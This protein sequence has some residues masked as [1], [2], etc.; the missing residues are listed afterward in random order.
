VVASKRYAN[1]VMLGD[2]AQLAASDITKALQPDAGRDAVQRSWYDSVGREVWTA[3]A[4]GTT[5][6]R[7]FDGAGDLVNTHEYAMRLAV[8]ADVST[9]VASGAD[10]NTGFTYDKAHRLLTSTDTAGVVTRTTYDNNGNVTRRVVTPPA[11]AL[12][13]LSPRAEIMTYDA[14]NRLVMHVGA[15]G[16]VTETVYDGLGRASSTIAYAKGIA[17]AE[18]ATLPSA[19]AIAPV[20]S[21]IRARVNATDPANRVTTINIQIGFGNHVTT[22]TDAEKNVSVTRL[23]GLDRT[24]HSEVRAAGSSTVINPIDTSYDFVG[25]VVATTDAN[26]TTE[27]HVYDPVGN[28]VSFT[29]RNG[30]TWTYTYDGAGHQLSETSP[31][32]HCVSLPA[33]DGAINAGMVAYADGTIITKMAYDALGRLISRTE[34]AGRTEE[35]TTSYGYDADGHQVLVTYPAFGVYTPESATALAANGETGTATRSETT[36]TPVARTVYDTLGNA[37][38]NLD[39]AGA[40][41]YKS[42]DNMGQVRY[43][44]DALGYVTGYERD[45]WGNVVRLTRYAQAIALPSGDPASGA[46]LSTSDIGAALSAT[47]VDHSAD[48]VVTTDYDAA[49]RA[50]AVRTPSVYTV[51]TSTAGSASTGY[52]Q[53]I[54]QTEY[55][56]FGDVTLVVDGYGR[57]DSRS[58]FTEDFYDRL[59]RKTSSI[60]AGG[61][62]TQWQYDALGHERERIERAQVLAGWVVGDKNN[63]TL[64]P[65]FGKVAG[66]DRWTSTDYDNLGRKKTETRHGTSVWDAASNATVMKDVSTTYQYDAVG[67]LLVTTEGVTATDEGVRTE[68]RFDALGRVWTV[69]AAPVPSSANGSSSTPYT[70]FDRDA[71]G[72]VV[73]KYEGFRVPTAPGE[74]LFK[75]LSSIVNPGYIMKGGDHLFSSDGRFDLH[76]DA[77]GV[78][79]ETDRV[80]N[81][82]MWQ[83]GPP[84]SGA[85]QFSFAANGDLVLSGPGGVVWS[86]GTAGKGG[87]SLALQID[88]NLVIYDS[89]KSPWQAIWCT[90]W[91]AP[92]PLETPSNFY[93]RYTLTQYDRAGHVLRVQDAAGNDKFS[94]VDVFGHVVKTWQTFTDDAGAKH[95]QYEVTQYDA[96]GRK[97]AVLTPAS[98]S[99]QVGLGGV[100][101]VSST[102]AT[103]Y[104]VLTSNKTILLS[105]QNT[106]NLNVAQ[107]VR[108]DLGS[109][110]VTVNYSTLD[111]NALIPASTTPFVSQPN[112]IGTSS[113][114]QKQSVT[115]SA[116]QAMSGVAF[117]W[118]DNLVAVGGIGGLSH[119]LVEQQDAAGNWITRYDG[120]ASAGALG[121]G[122]LL[123]DE[124]GSVAHVWSYNAFGEATQENQ[125]GLVSTTAYD[126]AGNAWAKW[127]AQGVMHGA[128]YDVL[129]RQTVQIERSSAA[130]VALSQA[131]V[132][133]AAVLDGLNDTVKTINTYDALGHVVRQAMP[134]QTV[135]DTMA[136][137]AVQL[138]A[139]IQS[140]SGT[141]PVAMG[142]PVQQASTT[143][144][145]NCTGLDKLGAGDVKVDFTLVTGSSSTLVSQVK[146]AAELQNGYTYSTTAY[147]SQTATL[148]QVTL[149]KRDQLGKWVPIAQTSGPGTT[150]T[151]YV[152][153]DVSAESILGADYALAPTT[154]VDVQWKPAGAPDSGYLPL[155][156]VGLFDN[157]KRFSPAAVTAN[158]LDLRVIV[159]RPGQTPLVTYTS[160]V[161]LV[162]PPLTATAVNVS[163]GQVAGS[164]NTLAWAPIANQQATLRV[165]PSGT[166]AWTA[167][168]LTVP[169]TGL[170]G[171]DLSSLAA[172]NYD[173]EVLFTPT[174]SAA[175]TSHATGSFA[176]TAA[177]PSVWVPPVNLPN[178]SVSVSGSSLQWASVAS[179]PNG[180]LQVRLAG[181]ATWQTLPVASSAG[182]QSADTLSLA[183]GTYDYALQLKDAAGN[184]L[185]QATGS[186][187][188]AATPPATVSTVQVPVSQ[189]TTITPADPA[190]YV[191][192]TAF[193]G[194][195]GTLQYGAP[196]VASTDANGQPIL[197]AGY[198]WAT[199]G[200]DSIGQPIVGVVA[201][202][203]TVVVREAFSSATP[204]TKE[205]VKQVAAAPTYSAAQRRAAILL[206]EPLDPYL[207][208][209]AGNILY[210]FTYQI[211]PVDPKPYVVG[212]SGG[213]NYTSPVFVGADANG[214]PILGQGYVW[215]N[216]IV[217]GTVLAQPYVVVTQVLQSQTIVTPGVRPAPTLAGSTTPPYAP[218]YNTAAIA[219]T[220]KATANANPGTVA[221]S[222]SITTVGT[223]ATLAAANLPGQN[224]P[225]IVA[226]YDRWGNELTQ[227]DVRSTAWVTKFEYDRDNHLVRQTS[228]DANGQLSAASAVTVQGYDALGRLAASMDARSNT[229]KWTYDGQGHVLA[230][231]HS[232][233][234]V[235]RYGYNAFGDRTSIAD[236]M[237]HVTSL[238]VD[239]LGRTVQ[240]TQAGEHV[241]GINA[242]GLPQDMGVQG[243]SQSTR[244]DELGRVVRSEGYDGEVTYNCWDAAGNQVATTL[245]AAPDPTA[246]PAA[247]SARTHRMSL[248][249]FDNQH[250]Q[251]ASRDANG[252]WMR[253]G[254]VNGRLDSHTDLGGNV[255][256]YSY[257]QAG[258]VSTA[259]TVAAVGQ[260]TIA[261]TDASVSTLTYSYD[262][263]GQTVGIVNDMTMTGGSHRVQTSQYAY[264]LAGHRVLERVRLNGELL[265]DNHLA[266]DTLGRLAVAADTRVSVFTEYDA[267]GNRSHVRT[268]VFKGTAADQAERYFVYDSMNRQVVV[269]ATSASDW[270]S[271]SGATPYGINIALVGNDQ[272][273]EQAYL[274][275]NGHR[276]TYDLHGNRTSDLA[277]GKLLHQQT[278]W[279]VVTPTVTD[280]YAR[281]QYRYDAL[282]RLSSA[283]LEAQQDNWVF[284]V[285]GGTVTGGSYVYTGVNN[286]LLLDLRR[287]DAGGHAEQSGAAT[288]G[289]LATL[290]AT[291]YGLS[292]T[293]TNPSLDVLKLRYGTNST[294]TVVSGLGTSRSLTHYDGFGQMLDQHSYSAAG[295]IQEQTSLV[296][297]AAG[298]VL[299]NHTVQYDDKGAQSLDQTVTSTLAWQDRAIEAGQSINGNWVQT[300]KTTN[301]SVTQR[302]DAAGNLLSVRDTTQAGNNRD[303]VNDSA[304]QALRVVQGD[305]V[306]G[307]SNPSLL[308]TQFQFIVNG[309]V[310]GRTGEAL[311][312]KQPK[313]ANGVPQFA[314]VQDLSFGFRAIDA[315]TVSGASS[316]T[317]Q[318]G[319]TLQGIAQQ[320]YGDAGLWYL[321]AEANGL[322][323]NSDLKVGQTLALPSNVGTA[324]NA[325]G[326]VRPYD[327]SRVIGDTSPNLP[328]PQGGGGCGG[329]GMLIV[330]V[331]AVV[332]A[333]VTQQ[334]VLAEKMVESA[335]AAG[336]IGAA[337]GSVA[338]QLVGMAIG[339]QD[340]FSWK[341]VGLAAVGGAVSGALSDAAKTATALQNVALKAAL[342]NAITQGIGVATGLQKKFD[343]RGVAASAAGAFAGDQM[344]GL[345]NNE[346]LQRVFGD[347]SNLAA[348]TI[349]GFV[350][351]TTTALARGGRVAVQQ[352]ATDAFGNALGE[353][354]AGAMLPQQA[355]P[356]RLLPSNPLNLDNM[357][358]SDLSESPSPSPS[359]T[360]NFAADVAARQRA[361]PYASTDGAFY[362]ATFGATF[363][364]AQ[365]Q[366]GAGGEATR[367]ITG[368]DGINNLGDGFARQFGRAATPEEAVKLANY[369]GLSSAHDVSNNREL[370]VPKSLSDLNAVGASGLQ[371]GEYQTRAALIEL[372]R[373][374][375]RAADAVA[376]QVVGNYVDASMQMDIGGSY[377]SEAST[378]PYTGPSW[379]GV[380]DETGVF[381]MEGSG[382]IYDTVSAN[383]ARPIVATHESMQEFKGSVLKQLEYEGKIRLEQ[384]AES[385]M[386]WSAAKYVAID[387]M[388]PGSP[389]EVATGVGG[390]YLAG[391]VLGLAG[392]SL[393]RVAGEGSFW[394][395]D[396]GEFAG[397]QMENAL[398]KTANVFR[399]SRFA[400]DMSFEQTEALKNLTLTA[401]E[402]LKLAGNT[403]NSL[404]PAFTVAQDMVTG[405]VRFGLN[406]R[407]GRVPENIVDALDNRIVN[408]PP[409]IRDGYVRSA[410][411]GTHAEIYAVNDLMLARQGATLSEIAV[412]TIETGNPAWARGMYKPA[413]PHCEYILNGVHYVK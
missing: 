30:A 228:V 279:G 234:G 115:V 249:V 256:R 162:A 389:G 188:V 393:A 177:V 286:G 200:T 157:V 270:R 237:N 117:S 404:G 33:G 380:Y 378:S 210:D 64:I 43:D 263:A 139:G 294:G 164:A 176:I 222:Q 169:A 308:H 59:G 275:V 90:A 189:S 161:Q 34:A 121:G 57:A 158:S 311:D 390:G 111:T 153:V 135:S 138:T 377:R 236:A 328:K 91:I 97:T 360:G 127:D 359:P 154:Q 264:D 310:L 24:I 334:Y 205:L 129:G 14:A 307:A 54:T 100:S 327:P 346:S 159:T 376:Q 293:L 412:S 343:W 355:Q 407:A 410:K 108:S 116:T 282:D 398:V 163:F 383:I 408:M 144:K 341:Q 367:M 260:V 229:T 220:Y 112:Y 124:A 147:S 133:T 48:R 384:G 215:Q 297:D 79:R 167:Y 95:T 336:A 55:N 337:A 225:V 193:S 358:F 19:L 392:T 259:S 130:T 12:G 411:A 332:V 239:A 192:S 409:E 101:F 240:V 388:W 122:T 269:D 87:T 254:Y 230:E 113:I 145:L 82:L 402:Q 385:E 41:S 88:G 218:G 290:S 285:T 6:L 191:N 284:N 18:V 65:P 75:P 10:R 36:R 305:A 107:L 155:N 253:W 287:Y 233:G 302:F 77:D 320:A 49:N 400:S 70:V 322:A 325:A 329:L 274:G 203:A 17:P 45:A 35:R 32:V 221:L 63:E 120:A 365:V 21:E 258:R 123:Q 361:N 330:V 190:G 288:A 69:I 62:V 261:G 194:Y 196:I 2:A 280:G 333:Y 207:Y 102:W 198:V 20:T 206:G 185:A 134:V 52:A 335:A 141:T 317:V 13:D 136:A 276:I 252:N 37:V 331:V 109:V 281:T 235:V 318:A 179:A 406:S 266:Y 349:R 267:A 197:A 371:V 53:R 314:P 211:N 26:L 262:Q 146:S 174:G 92:V 391:K 38:A 231:Q 27:R 99:R 142:I 223:Y 303:I 289:E 387:M 345:E 184:A 244:Y 187:N 209:A 291:S 66:N 326:T 125:A 22:V 315:N 71:Y 68:S 165:R 232:D 226:T 60:D 160:T 131:G 213:R 364:A 399:P 405:E 106:I 96:L 119:V 255:T 212:G 312:T 370:Y 151:N 76:L 201:V 338:S 175:P 172:G 381:S 208:D 195:R 382:P 93:N 348:A 300:G 362:G 114:S 56:V 11:G 140:I 248:A 227:S 298:N 31:Y 51:D 306:A 304:G 250:H 246:A 150:V 199:V 379:A 50:V 295:V 15:D 316:L 202:P 152:D 319:Q 148:G 301:G 353:S 363:G 73:R 344:K 352:I 5:V 72:N 39:V 183:A 80:G 28:L 186:V 182:V 23:D 85:T 351:G 40:V 296:T 4:D 78:L 84:N 339:V 3:R 257:D 132:P 340:R 369:N 180:V 401:Y 171:V 44:V 368:R 118:F 268:S 224:R 366:T 241:W 372:T 356:L 354:I 403:P 277:W 309:D 375:A 128:L 173:Y 98:I 156:A 273:S 278:Y 299:A 395:A 168:A 217:G 105:G 373:M 243:R 271:S 342:S 357:T 9:L 350:A 67:N 86:A 323:G 247:E 61:Y 42:Y 272:A 313:D 104:N 47:S 94:S 216:G 137:T 1:A 58:L 265:Q 149:S 374:Q 178:V 110:R 74:D 396:L 16:A 413:C 46:V 81:K 347:A 89:T 251:T 7:N 8:N 292:G 321:I 219:A 324:H 181:T 283:V 238:Q 214:Q 25:H 245:V 386:Q 204:P 170:V 103:W 29:N 242:A 394:N 83:A 143:V 397:T 126:N 166:S